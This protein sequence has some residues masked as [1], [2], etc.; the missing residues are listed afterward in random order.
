MYGAR[1]LLAF[2]L[3]RNHRMRREEL[4]SLLLF[5]NDYPVAKCFLV[6]LGSARYDERD[7]TVIPFLECLTNLGEII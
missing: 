1:G 6:N 2:E 3:K 4:S 7:I 5:K